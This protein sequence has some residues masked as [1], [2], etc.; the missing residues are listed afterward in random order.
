MATSGQ[1]YDPGVW[2]SAPPAPA[3]M[4][5]PGSTSTDPGSG[6]GSA[7]AAPPAASP[8]SQK[9]S[10]SR[11][12]F[13]QGHRVRLPRGEVN[14]SLGG[15]AAA[16]LLVCIHGLNGALSSFAA[17]EPHLSLAGFRVLCFDLYGFGLSA[18]PNGRLDLETY[19]DQVQLLLKAIQVPADEQVFLLGYSMGGVVAVEFARRFP[20]KV[21]RLLLVAPSGLMK[22]SNTP[23]QPLLFGCLRARCGGCLLHSATLLALCCGCF[24]RRALRGPNL[25]DKFQ[26][27]VREPEKFRALAALNGER[28]LWNLRRSVNSYLRALKRMPLWEEDFQESYAELAKSAVPAEHEAVI[29]GVGVS[30]CKAAA[31]TQAVAPVI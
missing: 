13:V 28:F 26:M 7:A 8:S 2:L 16:P 21:A 24:V 23:C 4:R 30:K 29:W 6:V 10:G 20:E 3:L 22:R 19:V 27:D 9:S 15:S 25:A 12:P 18:S 11:S 1:V 31:W 5:P 17:F 14:Y